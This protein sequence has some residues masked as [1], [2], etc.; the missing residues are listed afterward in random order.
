MPT[1][2]KHILASSALSNSSPLDRLFRGRNAVANSEISILP[3]PR[4]KALAC[5]T[6]SRFPSLCFTT[7]IASWLQPSLYWRRLQTS[8]WAATQPSS[9]STT[10]TKPHVYSRRMSDGG[11][12]PRSP[13]AEVHRCYDTNLSQWESYAAGPPVMFNVCGIDVLNRT[14]R[15]PCSLAQDSLF[16]LHTALALVAIWV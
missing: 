6:I 9:A 1:H 3:P 7:S 4:K 5:A 13:S 15:K 2:G 12:T 8:A 10:T 14:R 11:L 16:F